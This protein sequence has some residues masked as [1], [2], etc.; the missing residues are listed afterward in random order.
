MRK[1]KVKTKVMFRKFQ[2]GT[3]IDEIIALFPDEPWNDEYCTSY[4]HNGQHSGADYDYVL[5][6]SRFATPDEYQA[7]KQELESIGYT[8]QV[9]KRYNRKAV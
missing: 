3:A 7:L 8:L 1:A 4:M 2:N 6:N 5:K 9:M